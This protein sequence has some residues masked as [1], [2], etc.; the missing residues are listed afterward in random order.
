MSSSVHQA[1]RVSFLA[2]GFLLLASASLLAQGTGTI[3]GNVAD[4]SSALVPGAKLTLVNQDT[5]ISR[6]AESSQTGAYIFPRLAAGRY[7]MKAE[8]SGFKAHLEKDI[9]IRVD[10]NRRI[11]VSLEVGQLSESVSVTA[12]NV[13]VE[14]RSGS[15]KEV[16]DSRRIVD[17]PLNGRNPL[18]LQLLVAG[19]G[20]TA[21]Q[22]QGQNGTV[23]INGSRNNSNNYQLD[24]AD[25]HDPF[26]N[27]PSVFP[28]P[29]ALEEFSIQTSSYGADRGRNGGAFMTAVTKSGTNQFHGAV[30]EFLR[31]DKLNARNFFATAVPP[32]RRNQFGGTLGGPVLKNRTFFFA[33]YQGTYERSS[34]SA[35][36]STVLTA[37][38]RQG[39]FPRVIRDPAG[40]NFPNNRIPASRIYAPTT[41]FLDAFVP[42][43]NLADGLLSFASQ[44]KIDDHQTIVKLDH[45]ISARHQ[46]SGRVLRNLNKFQEATGNLPGF[47]ALLDYTNWNAVGTHTWMINPSALNTFTL[48]WGDISRR[49]LSVVPGNSTWTGFGAGV[50]RAISPDLVAAMDT[51]VDGYFQAFSRHPLDQ[52]RNNWQIADTAS[53]STGSHFL[54]FGGEYRYNSI[55]RV[56]NFRND[57]FL[58]F[59]NTFTG[60]AAADLLL[61]RVTQL[62]Q[63]SVSASNG[64]IHEL[65]LFAQDDWKATRRLTLNLGL[66][67]DPFIPFTDT[68]DVLA[69][70]R[71]GQQSTVYP[72]APVGTVYPGDAGIPAGAIPTRWMNFAPRLGFAFDPTGNARS[73]IR[74][75]YGIFYSAIRSQAMNG[76]SG[77]QPFNLTLTINNPVNGLANP[78]DGGNPFPYK[79]PTTQQERQSFRYVR[80]VALQ[81]WNHDF[82]NG[83]VQQW[84]FTLQRQ[85]LGDWIMTAAYV[86][87]KGN[88]L[89]MTSQANPAIF[90]RPGNAD[91]RRIYA[92][93]YAGIADYSARANS[94]YHSL[95]LTANKRLSRNFTVLANYTWAKL[96]DDASADGDSPANPFDFR[97]ERGPG[98]FDLTHRFVGS[99]LYALPRFA[100][101]LPAVR[102]VLGGWEANGIV[103]FE[104]GGWVNMVSGVDNSQAAT[105][106]DRADLAAN[107]F[108]D[109]GRPRAELIRQYFNTAAFRANA[110]GTFGNVGKNILR[111]PGAATTDFGL[112]KNVALRERLRLQIRGEFFNLFNRVNLGNPNANQ[113]SAN[114]GRIT[115]AGAPRV[116]Q[117]AL[118]LLF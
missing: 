69:A 109:T 61:G 12:E 34:P 77:N 51:T 78:Y 59:R 53:L 4:R 74:G 82:R 108:L 39:Q 71:P 38:Q 11:D 110:A 90:G 117:V 8:A 21:G 89:F 42:Q 37:D 52:F 63:A 22:G 36:T 94:L 41:K 84:N 72:T 44:Q 29:D 65:S 17:L 93:V 66:R 80:P 87:S 102:H 27:S 49:Q 54:K 106:A 47:F 85:M 101:A 28:S 114:F 60:D 105:N 107:P 88:H 2:S 43:P 6:S 68:N 55:D 33:S 16:V 99:F 97:H 62:G 14:T 57:P 1:S 70:F 26:F 50:V 76:L 67:W 48:S 118:K 23:S 35:T 46:F 15:V 7:E 111:G 32:F 81:A 91:A 113:G 58:R 19:S 116:A 18:Q 112:F 40:G 10:D 20:G 86:G 95:Q 73:S 98:D 45:Q 103:T 64:R 115:G 96:M 56:E 25:N 100:S 83:V 31:N 3:F 13:Q 104:S 92:P 30:F 24:N 79:V 75:G 9:E 5:G